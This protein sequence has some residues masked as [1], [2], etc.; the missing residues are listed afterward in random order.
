MTYPTQINVER[1]SRSAPATPSNR[2]LSAMVIKHDRLAAEAIRSAVAQS[3][4]FSDVRC[5]HSASNALRSLQADRAYLVVAGLSFPDIDGID[6]V[7]IITKQRLALR[8]MIVS[9]RRDEVVRLRLRPGCV[10]G[11]FDSGVEDPESLVLAARK[12]CEGGAYFSATALTPSKA[13]AKQPSLFQTLTTHELKI[14]ALIGDGCDDKKAAA[15]LGLSAHTLHSHRRRIMKKIGV[16]S[17]A[18]LMRVAI[19]RGV[20]RIAGGRV[21]R[22]GYDGGEWLNQPEDQ[23]LNEQMAVS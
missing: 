1:V 6:L 19:E 10:D 4:M 20:I 9:G 16:Q 7:H 22:P 17:R 8:L 3:F 13:G 18:D 15:R 14:F 2:H 21:F 23:A 5:V 11:F 12:V